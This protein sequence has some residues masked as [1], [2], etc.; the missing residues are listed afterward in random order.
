MFD[1]SMITPEDAGMLEEAAVTALDAGEFGLAEM[2]AELMAGDEVVEEALETAED[3]N[4]E[5]I[6]EQAEEAIEGEELH[7]NEIDPTIL[8]EIASA[9]ADKAEEAATRAQEAADL[10]DD[11]ELEGVDPK[12]AKTAADDAREAA[13]A[14]REAADEAEKAVADEDYGKALELYMTAA[15][16]A[17]TAE[18]A[19]TVA[20]AAAKMSQQAPLAAALGEG[21]GA[22]AKD[23]P[24]PPATPAKSKPAKGMAGW[25]DRVLAA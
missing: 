4:A 11:S 25:A 24:T 22:A 13:D 15:E 3:E 20:C 8:G 18:E 7:A 2:P 9:C 17:A 16:E 21:K 1:W 6:D 14:A 10:A 5:T 12:E 23:A 19:C